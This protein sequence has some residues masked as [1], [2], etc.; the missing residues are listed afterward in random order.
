MEKYEVWDR[1][2][3]LSG[4]TAV[5]K[6]WEG[7]CGQA[8]DDLMKAIEAGRCDPNEPAE[9]AAM[10]QACLDDRVDPTTDLF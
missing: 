5:I 4:R 3:R 6:R 9:I 10:F 1:L 7:F 8:V 2:I